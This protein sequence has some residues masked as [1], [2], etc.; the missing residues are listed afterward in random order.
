MPFTL[1]AEHAVTYTLGSEV[2]A[3]YATDTYLLQETGDFLLCEDNELIVLER[4][5][6]AKPTTAYTLDAEH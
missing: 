6:T 1:D 3:A 4:Q 2:A 5:S